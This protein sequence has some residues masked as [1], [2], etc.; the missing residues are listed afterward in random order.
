[1]MLKTL[2]DAKK[3]FARDNFFILGIGVRAYPRITPAFFIN[4]KKFNILC[5]SNSADD[6]LLKKNT[7][8]VYFREI[9]STQKLKR[10]D[11]TH[12]LQDRDIIKFLK[13][14]KNVYLYIY[15][16]NQKIQEIADNNGWTV[17]GNKPELMQRYENKKYFRQ[18]I[19][20]LNVL[21]LPN[22]SLDLKNFLQKKYFYFSDKYGPKLVLQI[23]N[24]ISGGGLG[25]VF[26]NSE[27]ELE[28]F[29]TKIKNGRY[30]EIKVENLNVAKKIEGIPVSMNGCVTKHGII[31]SSA[32]VMIVDIPEVRNLNLGFGLF[33]GHDW[34]YV[35]FTPEINDQMKKIV[36]EI[37]KHFTRDGYKGIYG[38]DFILNKKEGKVYPIECN[39]RYTGN[40]PVES[41]PVIDS[42][43]IPIDVFHILEYMGL[44]YQINIKDINKETNYT[45]ISLSHIYLTNVK[46]KSFKVDTLLKGGIYNLK[47]DNINFLKKS[48][49]YKDMKN[50][51]F[52]IVENVA[53][54]EKVA[55]SS[56]PSR[57]ARLIFK[58]SILKNKTISNESKKI[59]NKIYKIYSK[60]GA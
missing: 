37:G 57:F 31:V 33:C 35:D 18:L 47:N 44:D 20:K 58:K 8:L 1:M 42:G 26:V 39:P 30:N 25:T 7:D 14:K 13:N 48:M 41:M 40:F 6:Y 24:F 10:I 55:E 50:K 17:L 21:T 3:I 60:Y 27:K 32:R 49:Y 29:K 19:D 36:I 2:N 38:I 23:T 53:K 52:M 12:I 43:A 4:R 9:S 11:S 46:N 16:N 45:N 28:R 54:G 56:K 51:E 5:Y 59:I 34:G 15:K 22:E